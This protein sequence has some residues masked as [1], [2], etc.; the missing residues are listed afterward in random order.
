[1][2]GWMNG[3]AMGTNYMRRMVLVVG[4]SAN[5]IHLALKCLCIYSYY[6][7]SA[8]VNGN[9]VCVGGVQS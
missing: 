7:Y 6:V 3:A 4:S 1:M 5:W 8:R 9:Q 2:D